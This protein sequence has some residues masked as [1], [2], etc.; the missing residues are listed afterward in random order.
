MVTHEDV[1]KIARL[2]KLQIRE[3]ELEAFTKDMDEIINFADTIN[4]ATVESSD[5]DQI[6]HLENVFREDVVEPSLPSE[7][8]LRNAESQDDGYFL[9]KKRG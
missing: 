8:I 5:F 7:E 6:N 1:L 3:D 4:Q 9:V 2:S